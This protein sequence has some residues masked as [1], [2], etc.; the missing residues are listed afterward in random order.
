MARI[1]FT[2]NLQRHV[3]C[4]PLNVEGETLHEVL[5][6]AFHAYNGARTYVLDEQG[7]IRKHVVVFIDGIMVK[8]RRTLSDVVS[9]TSEVYVMQ[10]LSG[11]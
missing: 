6:A 2:G 9:S 11:G 1:V 7:E 4:P 3:H 10:A 5:A 8:D